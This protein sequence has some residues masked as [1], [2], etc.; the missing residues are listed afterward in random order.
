MASVSIALEPDNAAATYFAIATSRLP[1][2]AAYTTFV[3]PSAIRI[4][5]SPARQYEQPCSQPR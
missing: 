3:E 5:V 2:S 1:A 4:G